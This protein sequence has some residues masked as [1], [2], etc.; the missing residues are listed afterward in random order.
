MTEFLATKFGDLTSRCNALVGQ[1][2]EYQL[3]KDVELLKESLAEQLQQQQR[4]PLEQRNFAVL[5]KLKKELPAAELASSK[6]ILSKD[7]CASFAQRLHA[8]IAEL[9]A[10]CAELA[11]ADDELDALLVMGSLLNDLRA[12][13]TT[14][15]L[16]HPMMSE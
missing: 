3:R 8:S 12:L 7:D 5:A 13:Q 4:L 2:K 10:A 9:T 14:G 1:A 11:N 16:F 15:K 6:I